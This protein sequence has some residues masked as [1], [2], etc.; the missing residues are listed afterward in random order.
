MIPVKTIMRMEICRCSAGF[1]SLFGYLKQMWLLVPS[2]ALCYIMGLVTLSINCPTEFSHKC[3]IPGLGRYFPSLLVFLHFFWSIFPISF[4]SQPDT[5]IGSTF[6]GLSI[7]L[8]TDS[9]PSSPHIYTQANALLVF[10]DIE[11][12]Y[13]ILHTLF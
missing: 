8:V 7:S 4:H 9:E 6:N 10:P 1:F 13:F 3:S 12:Y 5:W 2:G 11:I